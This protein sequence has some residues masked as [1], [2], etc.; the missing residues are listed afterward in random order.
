MSKEK[1]GFATRWSRLKV[2]TNDQSAPIKDGEE[3]EEALLNTPENVEDKSVRNVENAV[4]DE[5]LTEDDFSDV[6]FDS[7]DKSA[8]YTRFMQSNVPDIIQQKALRK[9][10]DSDSVFEVLDGMNDY[11]EDFT[12]NGLAGKALKTAYKVGRGFL[13]KEDSDKDETD[14]GHDHK[15]LAQDEGSENVVEATQKPADALE[16]ET[17]APIKTALNTTDTEELD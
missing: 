8:D 12:G 6:D 10:W 5:M 14:E 9:L 16:V 17:N 15:K 2:E 3:Q 7:L 13:E 4:D 1:E 11:D